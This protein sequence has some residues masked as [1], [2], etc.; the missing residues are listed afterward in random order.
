MGEDANR[1]RKDAGPQVL[2]AFRNAAIGF[3][4]WTG[5]SNIAA[6]LRHNPYHVKDLFVKLGILKQ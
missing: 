3:L 2:A 4:R 6:A 1:T 5:V